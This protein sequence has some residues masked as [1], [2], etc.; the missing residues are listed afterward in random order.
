MGERGWMKKCFA[1]RARSSNP[2]HATAWKFVALFFFVC[3]CWTRTECRR[4]LKKDLEFLHLYPHSQ[5]FPFLHLGQNPMVHVQFFASGIRKTRIM[6][7]TYF[8]E[9]KRPAGG[10]TRRRRMEPLSG[11]QK[12]RSFFLLG[13]RHRGPCGLGCIPSLQSMEQTS[14]NNDETG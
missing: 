3:L 9:M 8:G 13:A 1:V 4:K 12:E 14:S 6:H 5:V 10:T 11:H 2:L 7:P